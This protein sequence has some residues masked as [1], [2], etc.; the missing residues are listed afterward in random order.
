MQFAKADLRLHLV[1]ATPELQLLGKEE[2]VLTLLQRTY[3]YLCIPKTWRFI[4]SFLSQVK[5]KQNKDDYTWL[6]KKSWCIRTKIWRKTA[7]KRVRVRCL[8]CWHFALRTVFLLCFL[9]LHRLPNTDWRNISSCSLFKLIT[10]QRRTE[11]STLL[12]F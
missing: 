9:L 2:E 12:R 6:R 11:T 5:G 10:Q 4:S 8:F 1:Q 7:W 3:W